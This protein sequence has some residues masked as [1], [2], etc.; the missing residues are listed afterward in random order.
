MREGHRGTQTD[1]ER[2]K[3]L[4]MV[5]LALFALRIADCELAVIVI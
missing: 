5:S 2:M 4:L 3:N 1:R